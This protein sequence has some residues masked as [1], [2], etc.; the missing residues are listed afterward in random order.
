MLYI[1]IALSNG[2]IIT[3]RQSY[4]IAGWC[5]EWMKMKNGE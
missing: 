1:T 5:L 3:L 4:F 2:E